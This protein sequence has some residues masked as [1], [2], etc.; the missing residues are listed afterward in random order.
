M[1]NKI[2]I[3][4]ITCNREDFFKKTVQSLP[5]VD[6]IVV[7][8][9]GKPYP[10]ACYPKKVKEVL[11]H[12]QNKCVG[13]SKNEA[14]RYMIQDGCDHL[15]L[16][17]D[18]I[19]VI[20]PNVCIEYIKAAE[21]SGIWHLNF[22]YHGPANFVPNAY[23]VKNPRQV[24]EY[25]D[26]IEIALNPHCVGAFSYYLKSIIKN[27]GYIDERFYNAWDHVE[28]TYRIIKMGLHPPFWWFADVAKSDTL[29]KELASSETNSTIRK[30]EEWLRKMREGA[31]FY[32]Y[33]HGIYPTQAQDSAPDQVLKCLQDIKNKYA[34]KVL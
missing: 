26:G 27:V 16:I 21:A 20:N 24:V 9:D 13:I 23:G 19:E 14:L 31:E 3:G 8:N 17:E 11:Q 1:K 22:G 34:R 29:L 12:N 7:V 4:V 25:P 5:E 18:D 28:H 32:R 33:K 30:T 6:T 15:F 10:P 2:G